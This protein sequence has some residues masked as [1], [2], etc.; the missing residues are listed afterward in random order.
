[1]VISVRVG[2]QA[3]SLASVLGCGCS[4]LRGGAAVARHGFRAVDGVFEGVGELEVYADA[5]ERYELAIL[6]AGL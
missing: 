6:C 5:F 4:C 1:M 2:G 3:G